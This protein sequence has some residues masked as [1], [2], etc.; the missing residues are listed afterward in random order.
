MSQAK[1]LATCLSE[2][3]ITET[4]LFNIARRH[5]GDGIAV[6]PATK[7][8]E[9]KHGADWEWWF[10]RDGQGV[11][12]RVQAK[13]LFPSGRYESLFKPKDKFGQLKKLVSNAAV[14]GL[15]AL[16]C[17]Y[18]HDTPAGLFDGYGNSCAHSY[19]RPSFWGCAIAL[20]RDVEL[21]G[22]DNAKLLRSYETPWHNLVCLGLSND[23]DLPKSVAQKVG[24]MAR[25][26]PFGEFRRDAVAVAREPRALPAYVKSPPGDRTHAHAKFATVSRFRLLGRRDF[27]VARCLGDYWSSIS[28]KNRRPCHRT[29]LATP[30]SFVRPNGQSRQRPWTTKRL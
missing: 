23:D 6:I 12:Y 22:S 20:P 1:A 19:H 24:R 5:L 30:A 2:E 8:Q 11:G 3:T 17:F 28:A 27:G 13:R 7:P 21:V 9:A 10:T 29:S 15:D 25:A 14:G 26:R 4:C 16:Y 18:N